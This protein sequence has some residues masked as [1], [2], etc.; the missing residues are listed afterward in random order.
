MNI[1][2]DALSRTMIALVVS[3]LASGLL[4]STAISAQPQALAQSTVAAAAAAA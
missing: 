4:V 3:A 2:L 1:N